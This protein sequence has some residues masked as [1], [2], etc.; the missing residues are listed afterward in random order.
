MTIKELTEYLSKENPNM[1]VVVA[2][3][4]GGFDPINTIFKKSVKEMPD[5]AWYDGFYEESNEGMGKVV[6]VLHK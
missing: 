4:E 5:R 1:E 3:Y 2:G 6:L